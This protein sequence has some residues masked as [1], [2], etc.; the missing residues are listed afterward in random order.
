MKDG[1]PDPVALFE[2]ATARAAEVMTNVTPA[3]LADPTPCT[4]WCVQDLI[5]HMVASTDYLRAALDGGEQVPRSGATR[6]DYRAGVGVCLAGLA[7]PGALEGTCRSP[8]GFEWP[9]D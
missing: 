5:D 9:L 6:A 4:E 2:R 3:Q 7:A 1:M 8:L